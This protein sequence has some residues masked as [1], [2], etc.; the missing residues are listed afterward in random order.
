MLRGQIK[1]AANNNDSEWPAHS[2]Y[3]VSRLRTVK[4]LK[5]NIRAEIA[6]MLAA[7]LILVM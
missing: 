2:P 3:S 1:G 6:N 5:P 7:I 4:D